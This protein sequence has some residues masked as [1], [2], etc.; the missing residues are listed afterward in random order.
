M[1]TAPQHLDTP[2]ARLLVRLGDLARRAMR[3]ER[4]V[5]WMLYEL[6]VAIFAPFMS[7]WDWIVTHR[8]FQYDLAIHASDLY[9][10]CVAF[11]AGA[12]GELLLVRNVHESLYRVRLK[13]VGVCV[14]GLVITMFL[15][16]RASASTLDLCDAAAVALHQ[17]E[18]SQLIILA[19]GAVPMSIG[20]TMSCL[21]V[22]EIKE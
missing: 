11:I 8:H 3:T 6:L 15:Y 17:K 19:L 13:L 22:S 10:M 14:L 1:D 9:V 7:V 18:R 4:L 20:L 12:I 16:T 21:L 5:K 2:P